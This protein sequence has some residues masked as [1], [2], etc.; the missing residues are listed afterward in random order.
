[1]CGVGQEK[2]NYDSV[3][4]VSMVFIWKYSVIPIPSLLAGLAS[5]SDVDVGIGPNLM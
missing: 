2:N 3:S 4:M 5:I 1:M